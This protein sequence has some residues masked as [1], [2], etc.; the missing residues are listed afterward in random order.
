MTKSLNFGRRSQK[1]SSL[2]VF[3]NEDDIDV[4]Y[5]IEQWTD[6]VPNRTCCMLLGNVSLHA[7]LNRNRSSLAKDGLFLLP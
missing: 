5:V 4:L 3:G 7:L 1:F 6:T 2:K